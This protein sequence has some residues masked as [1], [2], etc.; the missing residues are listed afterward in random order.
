MKNKN[1]FFL[2]KK[3]LYLSDILKVLGKKNIKKNIKINNISDLTTATAND[4]SFINNLKYLEVLKK[5]KVKYIIS[6]KIHF[7]KIK[8]FCSPIIVNNVL[9]SVYAIANLF[10]PDSLNDAIEFKCFNPQ[11]TKI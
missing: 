8:D 7:D 2:K 5:S 3:N 10:Y 11:Q 9:K 1:P 6:N 4:I